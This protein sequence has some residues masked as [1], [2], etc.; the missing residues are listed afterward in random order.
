MIRLPAL[1]LLVPLLAAAAPALAEPVVPARSAPVRSAPAPARL[2]LSRLASRYDA[3]RATRAPG[4]ARTSIDRSL[5]GDAA[6]AS[7]G[8]L[9][10]VQPAP[11]VRGAASALGSDRDGR[12]LGAQLR[13]GF[14]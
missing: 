8:L 9:C 12:F 1:A 10:G 14:R 4:V 3:A 6:T 5:S 7:L 11:D 2:D 13:V